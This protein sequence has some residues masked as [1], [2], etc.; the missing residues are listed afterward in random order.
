ML[1]GFYDCAL[2]QSDI[3]VQEI[4]RDTIRKHTKGTNCFLN[5]RSSNNTICIGLLTEVVIM[6]LNS[7]HYPQ[8]E[9]LRHP[10]APSEMLLILYTPIL[11]VV[12]VNSIMPSQN[13][14]RDIM[15]IQQ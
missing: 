13:V 3:I 11:E 14:P 1:Q 8:E 10:K 12:Y 15:V 7:S 5:G 4:G 9:S 6:R 2:S